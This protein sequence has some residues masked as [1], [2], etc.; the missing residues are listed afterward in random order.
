MNQGGALEAGDSFHPKSPPGAIWGASSPPVND[1]GSGEWRQSTEKS[2]TL[3]RF[4]E[5][6]W[7]PTVASTENLDRW[8]RNGSLEHAARATI[9]WKELLESYE[10]PPLDDA[11]EAELVE[12]VEFVEFVERRA[13]ELGDPITVG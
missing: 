11:I 3:E 9:R 5:C 6:F 7:R 8:T 10:A 4:R 13:V 1:A 2:R 12:F